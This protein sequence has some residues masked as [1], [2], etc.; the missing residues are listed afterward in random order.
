MTIEELCEQIEGRLSEAREEVGRLEAA[1]DA[2]GHG[3]AMR[4]RSASRRPADSHGPKPL[5]SAAALL[6]P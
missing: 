2:L 3:A 5:R 4:R 1:L 6:A